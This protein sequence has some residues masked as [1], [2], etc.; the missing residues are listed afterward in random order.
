MDTKNSPLAFKIVITGILIIWILAAIRIFYILILLTFTHI[1][2]FSAICETDEGKQTFNGTIRETWTPDIQND[3]IK[4]GE[5]PSTKCSSGTT[6]M[7]S[8][9]RL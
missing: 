9:N 4:V 1:Y 7:T 6:V 8:F 3:D 5:L 2:F